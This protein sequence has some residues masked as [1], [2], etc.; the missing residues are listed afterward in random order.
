MPSFPSMVRAP[1]LQQPPVMRKGSSRLLDR[2]VLER[3]ISRAD[4]ELH[5]FRM[6]LRYLC[7]DLTFCPLPVAACIPSWI[8]FSIVSVLIPSVFYFLLGDLRPYYLVAQLPLTLSSGLAFNSLNTLSRKYGLRR[9]LFLD[10]LRQ[11]SIKVRVEYTKLLH[12]AFL[13]LVFVL[14]LPVTMGDAFYKAFWYYCTLTDPSMAPEVPKSLTTRWMVS[15]MFTVELASFVYRVAV[16]F[17][18]CVLFKLNCGLQILRME[19]FAKV[20]HAEPDVVVTLRHHIKLRKQLRIISHRHRFFIISFLITVTASQFWTLLLTTSPH[21]EFNLFIGGELLVGGACLVGGILMCLGSAASITH[22]AQA[23]TSHAATWHACATI[24]PCNPAMAAE[25]EADAAALPPPTPTGII[26]IQTLPIDTMETGSTFPQPLPMI[27]PAPTPAPIGTVQLAPQAP[28]ATLLSIGDSEINRVASSRS[29]CSSSSNSSNRREVDESNDG[30]ASDEDDEWTH[31]MD[32][33][34]ITKTTISYQ[35]RQA[36][37][38]YLENN[39]GGITVYGFVVDRT[40][41]HALFMI[42]FSLVM[43]LLGKT[44]GI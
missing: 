28:E 9:S 16:L 23:L 22:K 27:A 20:F 3:S 35:K 4:D 17:L 8:A 39:K 40:W 14:L 29:I 24:N 43:W 30:C 25:V 10:Q 12:K 38:T 41:L 19:D 26:A 34:M 5:N 15:I 2:R 36:I 37:V 7:A 33:L 11:D 21:A 31:D 13:T 6:L 42:E 32:K 18:D 1:L 44:V